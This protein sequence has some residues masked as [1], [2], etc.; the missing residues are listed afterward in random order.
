VREYVLGNITDLL[1]YAKHEVF[2]PISL[3]NLLTN[4]LKLGLELASKKKR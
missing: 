3:V 2:C 4:G 1:R